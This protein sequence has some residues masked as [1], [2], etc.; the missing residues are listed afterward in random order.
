MKRWREAVVLGAG[1]PMFG[2]CSEFVR[3]ATSSNPDD[4]LPPAFVAACEAK[5]GTR[6]ELVTPSTIRGRWAT[7]ILKELAI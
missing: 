3:S 7:V 1:D 5:P 2:A 6:L 4:P